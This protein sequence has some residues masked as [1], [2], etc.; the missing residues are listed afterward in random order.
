MRSRKS[1]SDTT[2]DAPT[3]VAPTGVSA[4]E[5]TYGYRRSLGARLVLATL[6]FCFV[7][8]VL[9]VAVRTWSAW[10]D[11]LTD[12]DAELTLVEQVYRETLSKAI[13]EMDRDSLHAHV[14]SA[15]QVASVGRITLALNSINRA[16]EIMEH[17]AGGWRASSLAPVRRLPLTYEP[18]PGG[19]ETVGELLL[20]G[21][22]RVLWARLRAEASAIVMTQLLQSLLLAGLIMLLFDRSVTVHVQHIARHLSRITPE[23]LGTTLRLDR[24]RRAGDE[25]TLLETGVNQLQTKLAD[26][27]AQL[28]RY[29]SELA[30][31][32]DRLAELVQARTA[33]LESLTEVQQLVLR[34]SNQLIHAPYEHFDDTQRDCLR[35]VAQWLGANRALWLMPDAHSAICRVFLEWRRDPDSGERH[36]P[37]APKGVSLPAVLEHQQLLLFS[38]QSELRAALSE[39]DA[40]AFA[41]LGMG[42]CALARLKS[43]NDD[44]GFLLFGKELAVPGWSDE[45]RALLAMTSQILL[46]SARNKAQLL[47][48]VDAREALQSANN[49]LEDL[50]RHDPLT[51][52][53]N[54]RHFDEMQQTEFR[55]A[56]RGDQ[57]L[58][59]MICDIDYFKGYNDHYGHPGGDQ[60][61]R[62]V[63]EAMN[64]TITRSGDTLARIG[65]E[66]FAVLLP[67]T[68]LAA[69]LHVAERLRLSVA[70][71][72]MPHA[73][74]EVAPHVTIS[75]GVAQID[76]QHPDSLEA[77]F[78][79]ADQ[80]LYRAKEAG[81]NRVEPSAASELVPAS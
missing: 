6:G 14:E 46:Q 29:E 57:P 80:A 79:Q 48:I 19:S 9:T 3:P 24:S 4:P 26:H 38:G 27:L 68:P 13:W 44:F 49:R 64:K 54:R 36:Q 47:D 12:M 52:L 50:A 28:R 45:D 7:F 69:A 58:S 61:L 8:T 11:A 42:A 2:A 75:I 56:L 21:D 70:A 81:R 74:S 17:I 37:P 41:G 1:G 39:A 51:G 22:E 53:Y 71:M 76:L 43:D 63:A 16:P 65:G 78:E 72:A 62:T 18:Y 5:T 25:L 67:A 73:A 23:T 55:R 77:L 10:Q 60:C 34:L 40:S 33:E 20:E 30:G 59:L 66:E 15:G 31:H 32:R 35:D